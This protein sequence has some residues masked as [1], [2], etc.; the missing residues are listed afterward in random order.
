MRYN[1]S[2]K[3]VNIMLQFLCVAPDHPEMRRCYKGF[4]RMFH[5]YSQRLSLFC[6]VAVGTDLTYHELC[7]LYEIV[8]LAYGANV[9]R[10]LGLENERAINCFSG[11]DFV[12]W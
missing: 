6:N 9:P 12:S 5:E 8:V 10:K 7:N 4:E 11:S 3:K 2:P 1:S